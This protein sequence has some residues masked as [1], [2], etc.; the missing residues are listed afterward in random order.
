[1]DGQTGSVLLDVL[2]LYTAPPLGTPCC[3]HVGILYQSASF[4]CF[5][6]SPRAPPLSILYALLCTD[7]V[8][9]CTLI[10]R[11]GCGSWPRS[12]CGRVSHGPPPPP[13]LSLFPPFPVMIPFYAVKPLPPACQC[14]AFAPPLLK[15][16]VPCLFCTGQALVRHPDFR[17]CYRG[18]AYQLVGRPG[19]HES[20][21]AGQQDNRT[22]GEYGMGEVPAD[23][24]RSDLFASHFGGTKCTVLCHCALLRASMLLIPPILR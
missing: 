1:M 2:P 14:H 8:C 13:G 22:T 6:P 4:S 10:I 11:C 16:G 12:G 24:L 19:E 18:P 9:S 21:R 23:Q 20:T 3:S 15:F 7:D 5:P 17:P